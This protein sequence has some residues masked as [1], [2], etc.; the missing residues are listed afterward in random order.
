MAQSSQ[1][2]FLPR[3]NAFGSYELYDKNILGM[4]ASGYL[5]GAQL[6]W[7]VFDGYKSIGKMEKA[8]A[9][10][11]KSSIENQQYKAQSQIELNKTNRQLKDTENKVGLAQLA[12]QQSEEAYRIRN[13]RFQQGLEKPLIYCRQQP[14]CPKRI[15]TSASCFEYNLTKEYLQFLTK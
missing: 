9:E 5:V 4:G 1:M 10:H 3:L 6:S 8:K 13:N 14:K 12:L 2:N 11:Q 15:R 7:N